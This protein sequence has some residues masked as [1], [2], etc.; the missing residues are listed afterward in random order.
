VGELTLKT[1]TPLAF[2]VA[3]DIAATGR[4]VLVDGYDV[5]GGGIVIPDSYPRRTSDPAH[6]SANIFWNTGKVTV[7]QREERN[8]HPGCVVWLTGLSGSGKSTIA[9]EL[10]RALFNL[11]QHAYVLDGDNVRHGL[12]SDLGFSPTD[13]KEN[14]RR[15]G[16][17]AKLFADAGTICITAF[18]SPY[19]SDRDLARSIAPADR[20]VEVYLD[21]PIE[22]CEQ[23]DPKGLYAKARAGEIKEFTGVSAP[24]EAPEK[25]EVTL[26]T[27]QLS[28]EE[29]VAQIMEQL[30]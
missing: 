12:C 22:V 26:R 27:D 16:E 25:P 19:R 30:R 3:E 11:G 28:V 24:Y 4:F 9:A 21:T 23:R 17:V 10:E 20:F 18:I 6:K 15:L 7:A 1:K 14:I 13:R 8:G 2:D 5:A 29:C